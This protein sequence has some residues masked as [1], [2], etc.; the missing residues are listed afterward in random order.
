MNEEPGCSELPTNGRASLFKVKYCALQ[1]PSDLWCGLRG[2]QS[3]LSPVSRKRR[4]RPEIAAARRLPCQ[5]RTILRRRQACIQSRPHTTSEASFSTPTTTQSPPRPLFGKTW[6]KLSPRPF[7]LTR[8]RRARLLCLP[9]R[10]SA[11]AALLPPCPR[12]LAPLPRVFFGRLPVFTK[13]GTW[14][15]PS[16][17]SARRLSTLLWLIRNLGHSSL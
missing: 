16:V 14:P 5:D 13:S 7:G 17:R 6:H 15:S 4:T 3:V 1:F 10:S 12:P 2:D 11:A 8:L 9:T